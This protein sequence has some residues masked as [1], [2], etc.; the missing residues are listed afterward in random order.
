MTK[1]Q[2][3]KYYKILGYDE[4]IDL[5]VK[6]RLVELGFLTGKSFYVSHISPFG[7]CLIVEL[8]GFSLAIRSEILLFLKLEAR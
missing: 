4:Q 6:R 1:F 5:K 7:K 8:C 2:F 3:K